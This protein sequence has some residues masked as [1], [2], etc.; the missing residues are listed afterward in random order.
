MARKLKKGQI[1]LSCPRMDDF[2]A[3]IHG[4]SLLV[5]KGKETVIPFAEWAVFAVQPG[6]QMMVAR[7][8]IVVRKG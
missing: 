2:H 4:V 6:I 7:G 5:P 8:A 3:C 1:G